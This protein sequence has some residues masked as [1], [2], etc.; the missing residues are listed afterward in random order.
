MSESETARI[1]TRVADVKAIG[2]PSAVITF[3]H[4]H[5]GNSLQA[6]RKALGLPTIKAVSILRSRIIATILGM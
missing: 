5:S 3:V 6:L 1:L 2:R 4:G